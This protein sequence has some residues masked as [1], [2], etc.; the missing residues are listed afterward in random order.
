MYFWLSNTKPYITKCVGG[1]FSKPLS[2]EVFVQFIQE[3]CLVEDFLNLSVNRR[4]EKKSKNNEGKTFVLQSQIATQKWK[5]ADGEA[6][7]FESS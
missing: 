6:S 7:N 5:E 3:H 2:K 1:N 4:G